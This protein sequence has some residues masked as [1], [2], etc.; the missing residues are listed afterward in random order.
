[1]RTLAYLTW[2]YICLLVGTNAFLV[3]FR[4]TAL[5]YIIKQEMGFTD[6]L[7]TVAFLFQVL[8]VVNL[9]IIVK[10]RLFFFIF[11]GED[12]VISSRDKG[13][14]LLWNA[15]LVKRVWDVHGLMR[16]CIIMLSFDDMDMQ[17]LLLHVQHSQ[18]S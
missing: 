5:E 6:L 16:F 9:S 14:E 10:S 12:C 7:A 2:H 1:M 8:A 18:Q 17:R 4:H 13:K 3:K 15:L 11:G